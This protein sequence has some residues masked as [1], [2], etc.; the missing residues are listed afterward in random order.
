MSRRG[1]SWV[2]ALVGW[3]GV[4]WTTRI[5]NIWGDTGLTDGEKWGRTGLA[6]SFTVL[7]VAVGL[8]LVRRAAWLRT[9]VGA[10]AGW[11]IVVWVVRAV[12]VSTGGHDAAFVAV[13]LVLAVV[14]I[15]LAVLAGRA[16]TAAAP[17]D[18][19][20]PR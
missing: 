5:G 13:H 6:L 3:T 10:L 2:L 7:A 17:V 16:V 15:A 4:V 9:A 12:G 11:T 8:A 18:A 19:A 14:S 1:R 20:R